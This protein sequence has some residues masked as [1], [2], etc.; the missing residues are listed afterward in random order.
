MME[1]SLTMILGD[2]LSLEGMINLMGKLII[3]NTCTLGVSRNH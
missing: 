1:K 2:G 3:V